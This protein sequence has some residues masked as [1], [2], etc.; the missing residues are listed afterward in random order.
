MFWIKEHYD[1]VQEKC[2]TITNPTECRMS[3]CEVGKNNTCVTPRTGKSNQPPQLT[4]QQNI[5]TLKQIIDKQNY[6]SMMSTGNIKPAD[7]SQSNLPA[8]TSTS[9]QVNQLVQSTQAGQSNQST[10]SNKS[11]QSNQSVKSTQSKFSPQQRLQGIRK[12][13]DRQSKSFQ[14]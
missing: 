11:T 10:Q 14:R 12:I 6:N 7:F 5:S 2:V 13:A 8:K 1:L 4:P 3:G 9:A